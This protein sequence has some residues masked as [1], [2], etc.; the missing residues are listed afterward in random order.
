MKILT[1][2]RSDNEDCTVSYC[3]ID[4]SPELARDIVKKLKAF[5]ALKM[6]DGSL[7][8][9]QYDYQGDG[10]RFCRENDITIEEDDLGPNNQK[11]NE[12]YENNDWCELLDDSNVESKDPVVP[13]FVDLGVNE[14]GFFFTGY[15]SSEGTL[16]ATVIPRSV[17]SQV[18]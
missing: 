9:I 11:S 1:S 5:D 15:D 3:G 4:L 17:L 14:N 16:Y 18:I 12:F 13:E 8:Y 7:R 10:V 2:I 6:Q